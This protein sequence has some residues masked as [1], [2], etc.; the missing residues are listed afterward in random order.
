MQ[1]DI[2]YY[3]SVGIPSIWSFVIFVDDRYMQ[4]FA[5]PLNYQWGDLLWNPK[6]DLRAGLRDFCLHYLGDE[7]LQVVFP[8][9]EIT[10]T[11][12]CHEGAVAGSECPYIKGA[13]SCA[14]GR[15]ELRNDLYRQR[16]NLL[17]AE[18][19]HCLRAI[20]EL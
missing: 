11:K 18:Q 13:G 20:G 3:H 15:A 19:E 8:L 12:R 16:L 17:A 14:R 9:E 7:A 10:D 2:Q 1:H 4:R 5:S 6:A